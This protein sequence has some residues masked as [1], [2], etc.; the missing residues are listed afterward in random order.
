MGRFEYAQKARSP[1]CTF[2]FNTAVKANP[3]QQS[4]PRPMANHIL[5]FLVNICD[6]P[7]FSYQRNTSGIIRNTVVPN[8]CTL[9][10]CCVTFRPFTFN[11]MHTRFSL[12]P[13][14]CSKGSP[15]STDSQRATPPYQNITPPRVLCVMKTAGSP[16]SRGRRQQ[17]TPLLYVAGIPGSPRPDLRYKIHRRT[18]IM[19]RYSWHL[20]I[21]TPS[22]PTCVGYK[23]TILIPRAPSPSA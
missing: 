7:G 17:P 15:H 3:Q 21:G 22:A 12:T 9:C 8:R 23:N 5:F 2:R 13:F 14:L 19:C 16:S 18:R 11:P 1:Y 6:F 10:C 20:C 4:K